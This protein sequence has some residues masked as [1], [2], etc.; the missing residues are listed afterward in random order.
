MNDRLSLSLSCCAGSWWMNHQPWKDATLR[1]PV[2]TIAVLTTPKSSSREV[3]ENGEEEEF[4]LKRSP[5][6]NLYPSSTPLMVPLPNDPAR[7]LTKSSLRPSSWS[8][9]FIKFIVLGL[10]GLS[11]LTS[12]VKDPSNKDPTPIYMS[13]FLMMPK[14]MEFNRS[15]LRSN[16][17]NNLFLKKFN[18]KSL[19][20]VNF[21]NHKIDST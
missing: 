4:I 5:R 21:L 20:I 18:F 12:T 1:P 13:F 6:I 11:L 9:F 7:P 16:V 15:H 14:R 19:L 10:L 3:S 8:H 2:G 17:S